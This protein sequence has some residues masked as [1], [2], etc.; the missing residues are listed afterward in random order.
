[1]QSLFEAVRTAAPAGVW[2][3]GV[4]LARAGAVHGERTRDDEVALRVS[5]QGGI[6]TFA[7][8][9][10]PD[11]D[12]W[13][14]S[15]A[16][17]EDACE[18]V[19]AAVIALRQARSEGKALPSPPV[20]T[21]R[22]GY[23]FRRAAGALALERV[24]AAGE[25]ETALQTT[26]AAIA[27]GRVDGPR[28]AATAADLT[29]ERALGGRLKGVLPRETL[30]KVL[31]ALV[32][33]EDVR[34]DGRP[35]RASGEPVVPAGCLEDQGDGFHL[36][37]DLAPGVVE[38]FSNGVVLV[39]DVLRP[40]G[41][42]R[43]TGRELEE[44]TAGRHF[45]P[46]DVAKLV[47]EV[48]PSLA[49]RIPLDIRTQRL[50]RT[51][52]EPPR[53][54]F[55]VRREGDG[56]AVLP[57]LV[58][59]DP[60]VARVDAGKLTLLGGTVP[61][62]DVAAEQRHVRILQTRFGLVLGHEEVLEGEAALKI[63]QMLEHVDA[64]VKGR[65]LER[66]FEAPPLVPRLDVGGESADLFFESTGELASGR[67]F[68]GRADAASVLRAWRGG[69]SLIPLRDGGFARLP[70]AWLERFGEKVADFLAARE[71]SG[72]V[73]PAAVPD[74]AD[75]YAALGAPEPPDV[76][77]LRA[78][79]AE[80]GALPS[81][82]LPSDLRATL[83]TYQKAGVD[84]LVFL[85]DAGL[86]ALLA[87]DM[88]L[89]KTLQALCAI[90]GRTLVIAPTSVVHN[91]RDEI[92]RF[93]PTL[94]AALYHGARRTLDPDAD[95]T[96]TTYAILRLDADVL[97]GEDW[98]SVVLDEAQL[99]KNADSQVARAAFRL[100]GRFRAALTG[101]P[102]ENRLAELWSQ[103]H[104]LAPGFLG[105]REDFDERYAARIA[106]GDEHAAARLRGRI[107]PFVLRR[108]KRDVEPELPPR[109]EVVLRCT[110]S[111]EERQ[112]Y[113]TIRAATLSE[114][115][116]RLRAGGNVLGALEALLRL[117]QAACHPALIPGQ[118][119]ESSS[120]V[121]LLVEQLETVVA[122]GHKALVFSQWTSLLDLIEPR[123]TAAAI[124][125]TRLDGA[126][127]DREAVVRRFQEEADLPV[128]LVSLR[129]GGTGLNL[130]AADNVF[131]V[132]PWWNPAVEDQAADRAHRIGQTRP[133]FVHRLVAEDT[134]E[135]RILALQ[136][137]KR[138]LFET[139]LG[140]GTASAGLTREDLLAILE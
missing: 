31:G 5:T 128:M 16:S 140:G 70:E 113:D 122:E 89:G 29:V 97:A 98:D 40:V 66:F 79:T 85:R 68:S 137:E 55:Q 45:A 96:L 95:V 129:A 19:S 114:V 62:R 77:R 36:F 18:H 51:R 10:H 121:E 102:V 125:F 108:L 72:R 83:R 82:E 126:T 75:L 23:R 130:T 76:E 26:L 127:R 92:A 80:S 2:S 12:E 74:L 49:D 93:R 69:E 84:W 61:H 24:I 25:R 52:A 131:L 8:V 58:Y 99:I 56:L 94:R 3:R 71:P 60:P 123:L 17:S 90:R 46:G 4:E 133:V 105:T 124:D 110:L 65:G 111:E 86:G 112:V 33:G 15:C 59:G 63:A 78:L 32:D 39:G 50:P 104:F 47:T 43:L 101:T 6:A 27:S 30:A 73:T 134:I 7:V 136:A 38:S 119:A 57:T 139:A 20:T 14:C 88:G 81:S 28:F 106:S 67:S 48:L 44:L 116:E 120:K 109:T 118:A 100:R 9:L 87:D 115:V 91:W 22:V 13:E 54:I 64:E 117:R 135:E 37:V 53:L 107:R 42:T 138:S 103:F 41:Q 34:L 1:M 35:V 21:G 132:D 11:L